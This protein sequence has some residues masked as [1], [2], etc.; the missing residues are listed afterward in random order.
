[1]PVGSM[2]HVAHGRKVGQE[3]SGRLPTK[4]VGAEL[5]RKDGREWAGNPGKRSGISRGKNLFFPKRIPQIP[6][7]AKRIRPRLETEPDQACERAGS[8]LL[9]EGN[10]LLART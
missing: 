6:R 10:Q 5:G 8:S 1:M 2:A 7:S 9:G 3:E 4:G